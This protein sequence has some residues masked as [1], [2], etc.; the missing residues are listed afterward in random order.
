MGKE[1]KK[2]MDVTRSKDNM[3]KKTHLTYMY[4]I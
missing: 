1:I 3:V 4:N 2:E